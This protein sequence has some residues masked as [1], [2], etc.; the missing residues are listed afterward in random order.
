MTGK[1]FSGAGDSS[2]GQ[3]LSLRKAVEIK[4]NLEVGMKKRYLVV[5]LLLII[6]IASPI[7]AGGKSEKAAAA[8]QKFTM[9]LGLAN[10]PGHYHTK[11]A[12]KFAELM[13]ERTKGGVQVE[14]FPA[15]QLGT[16]PE[17][18]SLTS[19]G[20]IQM[21]FASPGHV[22]GYV[23]EYQI[24]LCPFIWRDYDHLKKTMQGPI[25]QEMA[26]KMLDS[27]GIRVLDALIVNGARHL[28]TANKAIMRPEDLR[29]M[30]IRAP[31]A[32]IYLAAVKA[33]GA[34][35]VPIDFAELYMALQQGVVDGEEN[36]LGTIDGMKFYEVQKYVMLTGH[37]FQS[38]VAGINEKYFASLPQEYRDAVLKA[39]EEAR[40]YNNK[41]QSESDVIASKKFKDLGITI[42]Q[43]DVEAFRANSRQ[44]IGE[45]EGIWGGQGLYD[46]I[47]NVK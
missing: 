38:Q 2:I 46:R 24:M 7:I 8:Q 25:G 36:A 3:R 26:K 28:T 21:F 16:E 29:G 47:V 41:L 32:P 13:A 35:P 4:K 37:I 45:L 42:I 22:G 44:F 6:L 34:N 19:Q 14:V 43:P 15:Q 23:K 11:A 40:D 18:I 17:M 27:H 10:D 9:K 5:S 1:L 30:K 33:M 20:T 31:Q 12:R 39:I